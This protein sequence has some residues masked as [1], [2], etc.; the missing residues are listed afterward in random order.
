ESLRII[1]RDYTREAGV[2]SLERQIGAVCRKV[3]T[4]IAEGQ[5]ESVAVEAAEVSEYL[6]K[7]TFFFEAAE[8]CDLPGVATGLSV[9]AV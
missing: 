2:R 7:P 5:M 4:R 3:A 8:R 1:I 9:T 6:G